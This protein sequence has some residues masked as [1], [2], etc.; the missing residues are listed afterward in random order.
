EFVFSDVDYQT[1]VVDSSFTRR[2][3]ERGLR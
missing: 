2:A 1:P 3:L